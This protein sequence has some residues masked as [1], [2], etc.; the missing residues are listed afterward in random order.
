M[1]DLGPG[2]LRGAYG[3]P[4]GAPTRTHVRSVIHAPNGDDYGNELIRQHCPASPH[5]R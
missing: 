4:R 1:R 2:P 3:G 5:H